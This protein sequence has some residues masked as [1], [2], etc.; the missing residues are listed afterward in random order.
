MREVPEVPAV[1]VA[2][3][4]RDDVKDLDALLRQLREQGYDI[5]KGAHGHMK[6]TRQGRPDR[7]VLRVVA[8]GRPGTDEPQIP[9]PAGGGAPMSG[10][11]ARLTFPGYD[12]GATE[13]PFLADEA[14]ADLEKLVRSIVSRPPAPGPALEMAVAGV[15][16][17]ADDYRDAHDMTPRPGARFCLDGAVVGRETACQYRWK[18]SSEVRARIVLTTDPA[19]VNCPRCKK[20]RLYREAAGG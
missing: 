11:P 13:V 17:A 7:G 2:D 5:S 20:S 19:K 18:P 6:D 3:G 9:A 8:L 16:A 12:A 1:P 15:M 14:R 4:R 10:R